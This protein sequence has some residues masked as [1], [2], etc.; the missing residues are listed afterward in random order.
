MDMNKYVVKQG[1]K[2]EVKPAIKQPVLSL[3]VPPRNAMV[4]LTHL[5]DALSCILNSEMST[6]KAAE[7]RKAWSQQYQK[8]TSLTMISKIP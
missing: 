2:A 7:S 1:T 4:L 5:I 8:R 6:K 3:S